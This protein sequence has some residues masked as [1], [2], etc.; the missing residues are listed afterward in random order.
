MSGLVT[1]ANDG[2][3]GFPYSDDLFAWSH[4][5]TGTALHL[6]E[7]DG[8]GD[9]PLDHDA[10]YY[11]NWVDET[12]AFLGDPANKECNV[13]MWSW[14]GQV[15]GLSEAQIISNY[16]EPMA[17]LEHDYPN[18]V[19]VYMTGHLDGTGESG[20]LHQRNEQIRT[21][22]DATNAW[23]F[24][25]ADIESHDPEGIC[26]L[27][28]M[29][30]DACDYDSNADGTRDANWATAW[31]NAHDEGTDWYSC[32]SAHSQPLNAN[33]KAYAAWWLFTQI[34]AQIAI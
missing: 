20:N 30:N 19:F 18:I 3:L 17:E 1:F 2:G 32:S 11:P 13:I 23:L 14:C 8:Y 15:S 26:Y 34:A 9:G 28:R 31:Q 4:D 10:G 25:F 6:F 33:M 27:D 29:A 22:C 24:D 21:H 7:G 12:R 5:A 16:L